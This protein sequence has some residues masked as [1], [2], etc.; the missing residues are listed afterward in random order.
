MFI[1]LVPKNIGILLIE[2]SL[3][4]LEYNFKLYLLVNEMKFISHAN[5]RSVLIYFYLP[6]NVMSNALLKYYFVL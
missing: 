5:F 4:H 2:F 1:I 6:L 3:L